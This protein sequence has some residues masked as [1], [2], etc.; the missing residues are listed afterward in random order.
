MSNYRILLQSLSLLNR[1][2][3]IGP[4]QNSFILF[5]K[6]YVTLLGYFTLQD[7]NWVFLVPQK[8]YS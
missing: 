2:Q 8:M 4:L 7:A 1:I 6:T 3:P 5:N